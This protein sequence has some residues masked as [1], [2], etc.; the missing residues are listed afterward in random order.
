MNAD[1]N[2]FGASGA[3]LKRVPADLLDAGADAGL[4][5]TAMGMLGMPGK[6]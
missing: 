1:L 4:V 5:G 2:R 6:G 3:F